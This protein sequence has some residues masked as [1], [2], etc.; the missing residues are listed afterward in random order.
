[1]PDEFRLS[2]RVSNTMKN[3]LAAAG[4][5]TRVDDAMLARQLV[6]M[7]RTAFR[8]SDGVGDKI[9][10]EVERFM[11]SHGH[12]WP[13]L[14][15]KHEGTKMSFTASDKRKC[16]ERELVMRLRVYERHVAAGKMKPEVAQREIR[17]MRA[18][19]DDYRRLEAEEENEPHADRHL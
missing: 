8:R 18:I 1:M 17:L 16:A 4:Y 7:G 6:D 3:T 15:P 9:M 10:L 14:Y 19:A 2:A 12:R 5:D 13:P 11:E